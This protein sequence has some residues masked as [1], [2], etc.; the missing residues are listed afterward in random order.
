MTESISWLKHAI[1][2]IRRYKNQT[3]VVK[4]GGGILAARE[5]VLNLTEQIALLADLGIRVVLVHG[6][7]AQ[8][9]EL[10][11]KLGMKPNIVAGRRVTD[12]DTLEVVKMT[13]GGQLK[14]DLVSTFTRHGM[15]AVGLTGIDSSLIRAN[16]RPPVAIT[17][18]DG[19]HRQVDFGNVGDIIEVN[20]ALLNTLIDNGHL[21]VVA[22][23]GSDGEGNILNINA[24]TVAEAIAVKMGAK[25][26]IYVTEVPGILRDKNDPGSLVPFA[27][28][29]DLEELLAQGVI[30]AGMRPKVQACLRACTSGVKRTHIVSGLQ[31]NSLLMEVFTGEGCGTMIVAEREKKEYQEHELG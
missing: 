25:K 21:P 11:R 10:S 30:T 14:L 18:D 22:S 9:S 17:D 28:A 6:G 29:A 19:N 3:F 15:Q 7:G 27:D 13:L 12:D 16:R 24:D 23:L 4:L 26:L 2:Y 31:E 1:P 5:A 20:P 8:T